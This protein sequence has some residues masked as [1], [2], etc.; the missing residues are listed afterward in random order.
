MPPGA[1][2]G[3][4]E[5]PESW[6]EEVKLKTDRTLES[7]RRRVEGFESAGVSTRQRT[8]RLFGLNQILKFFFLVRTAPSVEGAEESGAGGAEK[9]VNQSINYK[10]MFVEGVSG[11]RG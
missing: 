4:E 6:E 3:V 9:W 7:E 11:F 2:G 5:D 1:L 8:L 10:V